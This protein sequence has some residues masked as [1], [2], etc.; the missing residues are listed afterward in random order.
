MK[1]TLIPIGNSHGIRI[2]EPFIEQCGLEKQ[3]EIDVCGSMILIRAPRKSRVGWDSAFARMAQAGDDKM[4][5]SQCESNQ[6][7][8]VLTE[9]FQK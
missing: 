3:V 8:D 6:V 5:D 4:L 9:M 2:P 7:L 1:T